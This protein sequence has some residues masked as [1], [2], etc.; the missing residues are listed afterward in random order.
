M[1]PKRWS[2]IETVAN[3]AFGLVF[4]FV[5]Y[6]LLN[7]VYDVKMTTSQTTQ[8]TVWFTLA[9][10]VRGYYVRRFFNWV[11]YKLGIGKM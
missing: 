5:I 9:S 6:I 7:W 1:Q 10:V 8:Y 3:T 4:S 11:H 2:L